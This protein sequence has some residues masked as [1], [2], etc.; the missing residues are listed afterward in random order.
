VARESPAEE[1][2]RHYDNVIKLTA[3]NPSGL[4]SALDE[5]PGLGASLGR[6][7]EILLLVHQHRRYAPRRYIRGAPS[8]FRDAVR[9]FEE[10]WTGPY[11][12]FRDR[13][14]LRALSRISTEFIEGYH[15]LIERTRGDPSAIEFAC[16]TDPELSDWI[17][18][19]RQIQA[20]LDERD[21]EF[22]RF[23]SHTP[24][25]F[26]RALE[27]VKTRWAGALLAALVAQIEL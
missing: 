13:M 25:E 15:L 2:V 3:D 5:H 7:G 23:L 4:I 14:Y 22:G 10:R 27:D 17:E 1:F 19:L 24:D 9:D 6:L 20:T 16:R 8:G 11:N 26:R 21:Q 18:V 12:E